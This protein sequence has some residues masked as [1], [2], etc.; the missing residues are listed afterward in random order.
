MGKLV[1]KHKIIPIT[2]EC[3]VLPPEN[4]TL[5]LVGANIEKRDKRL[6]TPRFD[7]ES[8]YNNIFDA[9]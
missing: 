4:F 6:V 7:P 9:V 2:W 3:I 1:N 5:D 8:L